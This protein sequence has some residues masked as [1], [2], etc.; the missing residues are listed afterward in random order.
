MTSPYLKKETQSASRHNLRKDPRILITG[1]PSKTMQPEFDTSLLM[2]H[3]FLKRGYDVDYCDL[4]QT[5]LNKDSDS[6]LKSLPVQKVLFADNDAACFI[7]L[8]PVETKNVFEDYEV[9]LHRK[10]PPVDDFFIKACKQFT[11]LPS[12]ILQ[13]N[14]PDK[15][16]QLHEHE[17][18]LRYPKFSATTYIC[19]SLEEFVAAVRKCPG[20]AVCKPHNECSGLGIEFYKNDVSQKVLSEYWEARKPRVVV[21]PF[22]KDI[23]TSGDLRVLMINGAILGSV[24][25]VPQKGS[26]LANLHQGAHGEAFEITDHHR[27]CAK[28]VA[29]DLAKEGIYFIGL[30]FIGDKLTEVNITSPT[31]LP[32]INRLMNI[33]GHL[34]LVDEIEILYKENF[35]REHN[36]QNE[37][38][39]N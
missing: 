4:F 36:L 24:L 18:P 20:E 3:E 31:A 12:T 23:E 37:I 33:Q 39:G 30:D 16:W 7:G 25:R 1:D 27:E 17:L 11:G 29:E 38:P 35:E 2:A 5:D 22:I 13:L 10:D 34:T 14:D 9:I 15:I 26:R 21:Q 6:Y 8:A 28:L 32:L 19:K